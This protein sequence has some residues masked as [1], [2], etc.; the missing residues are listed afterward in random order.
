MSDDNT[1]ND[2]GPDLLRNFGSTVR[3]LRRA[4]RLTQDIL[5]ERSGLSP[6]TIRRLE[7]GSFS[8]SLA[9]LVK[10]SLGLELA[11]S[12]LF[13]AF[14]LGERDASR[15]LKDLIAARSPTEIAL[16]TRLL[17]ALFDELDGLESDRREDE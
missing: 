10:L 16:A 13:E 3:S 8:P 2:R 14:E 6:D 9:T 4:R 7:R 12:T 15:E 17:R 11:L 1:P 5:A